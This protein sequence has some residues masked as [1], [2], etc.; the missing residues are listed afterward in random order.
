MQILTSRPIY[1]SDSISLYN[2]TVI[3]HHLIFRTGSQH[4]LTLESGIRPSLWP[5][6]SR[7]H[8]P[9]RIM[10]TTTITVIN[11]AAA[12]QWSENSLHS[13]V[14]GLHKVQMPWLAAA[15]LLQHLTLLAPVR[16]VTRG[17]CEVFLI[18]YHSLIFYNHQAHDI[19]HD[20]YRPIAINASFWR[21]SQFVLCS[22]RRWTRRVYVHVVC[23]KRLVYY[24]NQNIYLKVN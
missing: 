9:A 1:N 3:I 24:H 13:A 11:D 15:A 21:V 4:T 6:Q 12:S 7:R 19:K 16:L 10:T 18:I 20:I 8:W 23:L 5:R 14:C 17:S 2:N 22:S